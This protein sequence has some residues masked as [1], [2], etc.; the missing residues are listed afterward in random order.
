[1]AE[2][3]IAMIPSGYKAEKIYSVLPTNGN[4]DLDFSRNS[5]ATRINEQGLIEEMAVNVPLLDY[6]DGTCPSLLLQPQST[7]LIQYSEDFSSLNVVNNA[8]VTS[9][10]IIS[11]SGL[12]DADEITFDGTSVGRVESSIATTIGQPYTISLYLKNKDLSDTTQVWIGFSVTSQGQFVTITN[13][14]QRYDITTNADGTTEYPRI[15]FSGSGSLYAWGFQT[16]QQSFATSYIKTEGSTQTR[17]A[18]SASKTGLSSYI[19]SEEG[20]LYAEI[21]ALVSLSSLNRFISLCDDSNNNNVYIRYTTSTNQIRFNIAVD[22]S[23]QAVHFETLTDSTDFVKVAIKY[24]EN[25]FSFWINGVKVGTD[26]SGSTFSANTLD[27][28]NFDDGDGG[29][30]FYGKCKD[31]RVYKI[32]LTD[33]QLTTLTTI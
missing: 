28:L 32:A 29:S 17:L 31:L 33:A 4:A 8:V 1:M 26:T 13:E 20:V 27:S 10:S 6:S 15:Q 2:P 24:K 18:E 22:S 16:E 5:K 14:W 12:L 21:A 11:P 30:D 19:N 7:N 23:T 25:D 3:S 9:N